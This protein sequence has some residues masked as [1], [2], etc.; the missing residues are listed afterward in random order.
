[1]GLLATVTSNS[2]VGDWVKVSKSYSDFSTDDTTNTLAMFTIPALS[3]LEG[4]LIRHSIA[5]AGGTVST[6]SVS[7]VAGDQTYADLAIEGNP[8][9]TANAGGVLNTGTLSFVSPIVVS[10]V[11]VSVDGD[12]DQLTQGQLDVYYKV[13]ALPVVT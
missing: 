9:A 4:I 3:V 1:M 12:L 7:I 2:R 13:S 5:F 11:I 10:A 6:V 8:P